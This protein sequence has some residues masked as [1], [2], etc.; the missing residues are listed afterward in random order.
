MDKGLAV[1]AV[2]PGRKARASI[3]DSWDLTDL[4]NKIA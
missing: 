3:D 4:L 1:S 2:A